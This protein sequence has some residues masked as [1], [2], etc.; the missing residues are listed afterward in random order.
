MVG[1]TSSPISQIP[2]QVLPFSVTS[3]GTV[4][5]HEFC[6]LLKYTVQKCFMIGVVWY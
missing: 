5:L 3:E 1:K 6:S 4:T 2:Q